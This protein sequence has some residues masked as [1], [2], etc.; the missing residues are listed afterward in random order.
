M[1]NMRDVMECVKKRGKTPVDPDI[2]KGIKW[3]LCTGLLWLIAYV[4]KMGAILQDSSLSSGWLLIIAIAIAVGIYTNPKTVLGFG[5]A[6]GVYSFLFF[7]PV[8]GM[9][10]W[11]SLMA[12]GFI[13]SHIR[14]IG[15][16]FS[17]LIVAL[18]YIVSNAIHG[19]KF[20]VKLPRKWETHAH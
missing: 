1:D 19:I 14:D 7:E 17:D 10:K 20:P 9:T 13:S 15:E 3:G 5:L 8:S 11:A 12:V 2:S 4:A 6:A 18:Y 16:Y